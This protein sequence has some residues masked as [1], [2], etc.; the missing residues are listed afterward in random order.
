MANENIIQS[1]ENAF[2]TAVAKAY[3][4]VLTGEHKVQDFIQQYEK[5]LKAHEEAKASVAAGGP[6]ESD[7]DYRKRLLPVAGDDTWKQR[8]EQS[9][10]E[11]LDKLGDHYAIARNTQPTA[12]GEQPKDEADHAEKLASKNQAPENG[13]TQGHSFT[14][15]PAAKSAAPAGSTGGGIPASQDPAKQAASSS[16]D[17]GNQ[18]RMSDD[19]SA[20]RDGNKLEKA[21]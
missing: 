19:T 16:A 14:N 7:E 21:K 12:R 2:H 10:G 11:A 1:M 8:I 5:S 18:Q 4:K 15:D 13:T 17:A 6:R 20:E 3:E 9:Q